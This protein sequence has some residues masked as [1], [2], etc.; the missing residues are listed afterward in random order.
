MAP[1]AGLAYSL[2][3]RLFDLV[4]RS[5][6]P[7]ERAGGALRYRSAIL[8][9]D[10]EVGASQN[11]VWSSIKP[12]EL[13][14]LHSLDASL[15]CRHRDGNGPVAHSLGTLTISLSDPATPRAFLP[16]KRWYDFIGARLNS[17][18]N[19][20]RGSRGDTLI[21]GEKPAVARHVAGFFVSG[22]AAASEG[23]DHCCCEK[24]GCVADV[25][26]GSAFP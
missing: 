16:A 8:P 25:R 15:V 18:A 1:A 24:R 6:A 3:R 21:S 26:H 2:A 5:L 22:C 4:G 11:T 13:W 10:H 14:Q 9:A 12:G 23:P 20:I 17:D 19:H 7:I